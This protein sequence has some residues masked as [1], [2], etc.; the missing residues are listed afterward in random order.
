VTEILKSASNAAVLA[1]SRS[2]R[3]AFYR[4]RRESAAQERQALNHL[5]RKLLPRV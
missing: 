2:D 4:A 5:T 3:R 1:T